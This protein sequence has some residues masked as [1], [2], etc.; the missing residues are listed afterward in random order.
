MDKPLLAPIL[1]DSEKFRWKLNLGPNY[2]P[3]PPPGV[4]PVINA[5]IFM[6]D[7][8]LIAGVVK[9]FKRNETKAIKAEHVI[10]IMKDQPFDV[11]LSTTEIRNKVLETY[12][13]NN[14]YARTRVPNIVHGLISLNRLSRSGKR[15]NYKHKYIY[16]NVEEFL[17]SM[18]R[19]YDHLQFDDVKIREFIDK[20]YVGDDEYTGS[21]YN[22][23]SVRNCL[24]KLVDEGFI[25]WD[26]RETE[27]FRK[28]NV[29]ML[30][31]NSL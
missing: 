26:I 27:T 20:Y 16:E 18:F 6:L 9:Y 30:K 5:N 31:I 19:N 10:K 3:P 7:R 13:V 1:N 28:V 4:D 17:R 23:K 22:K 24:I 12:A 8:R 14:E 21:V 2:I 25:S 15:K 29:F 11:Q